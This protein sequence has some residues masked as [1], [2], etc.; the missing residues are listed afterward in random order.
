MLSC[1]VAPTL[2]CLSDDE[3]QL[4]LSFVLGDLTCY[5]RVA[6]IDSRFFL[7]CTSLGSWRD[8]WMQCGQASRPLAQLGECLDQL[9]KLSSSWQLAQ[10]VVL[11]PFPQRH[12]LQDQLAKDC[13]RLVLAPSGDGLLDHFCDFSLQEFSRTSQTCRLLAWPREPPYMFGFVTH[14]R[15]KE[16]SR[17]VLCQVTDTL[18]QE[19][20]DPDFWV[21]NL[22]NS[23]FG[24]QI[25]SLASSEDWSNNSNG[26]YDVQIRAE[27]TFTLTEVWHQ[28]QG[29]SEWSSSARRKQ[30]TGAVVQE[31][32]TTVLPV[33]FPP[34]MAIWPV[35]LL[36]TP[37]IKPHAA[38]SRIQ[39]FARA[40]QDR[41]RFRAE[42]L[43][44]DAAT[45][46][47][48]TA[49][50]RHEARKITKEFRRKRAEL[51]A[52]LLLQRQ[53]RG[54]AV[55]RSTGPQLRRRQH[56]AARVQG[57]ARVRKAKREA[58]WTCTVPGV[59]GSAIIC[60]EHNDSRASGHAHL[61]V[62]R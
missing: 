20:G 35:D 46:W 1:H 37:N 57:I 9:L 50:R 54:H 23:V 33:A 44:R 6:A 53:F 49:W 29:V 47:I 40:I 59:V 58:M 51:R 39:S 26:T 48:Q 56:A 42:R 10:K 5:P 13:P 12:R 17:G 15:A 4:I 8:A 7:A 21:Q 19:V 27:A 2:S 36:S 43:R 30:P 34:Q 22:G 25:P 52:C 60:A 32:W 38:A 55:R 61:F 11:P 62:H 45:Q 31:L 28:E 18:R 14:G 41:K 24:L 3:R 16:G